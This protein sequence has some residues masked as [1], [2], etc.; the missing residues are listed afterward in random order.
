MGDATTLSGWHCNFNNRIISE[1]I[2][3]IIDTNDIEKLLKGIESLE[4]DVKMY[5][6]LYYDKA[7]QVDFYMLYALEQKLRHKE[8]HTNA[9]KVA[10]DKTEVDKLLATSNAFEL[11][12]KIRD[13]DPIA[14]EMLIKG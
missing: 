10:V 8:N 14:V 11:E 3:M 1:G 7:I 4:Q 5:K 2:T 12:K 6:S 9:V 13:T